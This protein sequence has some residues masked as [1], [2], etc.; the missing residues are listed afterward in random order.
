MRIGIDAYPLARNG[1]GISNYLYNLVI[2]LE[3]FD[4]ENEYYLYSCPGIKLPF[5]NPRWHIRIKEGLV[6]K[7]ATLWMQTSAIRDFKKDKIDIVWAPEQIAPI[8]LPRNIKLILNVHDLSWIY[9]PKT[10]SLHNMIIHKFFLERSIKRADLILFLSNT[11]K[12]DF[13]NNFSFIGEPKLKVVYPALDER[14]ERRTDNASDYIRK[15]FSLSKQYFL[16]VGTVEPRKNLKTLIKAY[17]LL[18]KEIKDK[19]QL[20]AVG[21]IGWKNSSLF[22]LYKKLNLDKNQVRFLGYVPKKDLID[23]YHEASLFIFPSMYEG[24]GLPLLEAMACKVPIV[25]SDIPVFKEIVDK[26]AIFANPKNAQEFSNAIQL[27]LN[28]KKTHSELIE[29][30]PER[31]NKF[32]WSNSSRNL[33]DCFREL[34]DE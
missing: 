8:L 31:I 4:S 6:N 20:L 2:N 24:F 21:E 28:D 14:F 5:N 22:N 23:L 11:L 19:F 27:V 29:N 25:C 1:A 16:S 12:E 15:K 30:S 34:R 3:K 33:L 17:C 32:S 13:K 10:M 18:N 9:Y 26:N 7:S